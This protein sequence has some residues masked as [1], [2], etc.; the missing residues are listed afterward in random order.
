M[1]APRVAVLGGTFDPF[2]LGHLAVAVQARDVL[3]AET[4]WVIPA[5][6]PPLRGHVHA[7]FRDRLDICRAV[8][9]GMEK[10]EV[11]DVE[12]QRGGPS[13]TV[14]TMGELRAA[15]PD[16]ELWMVLGADAARSLPHWHR[17]E[18]ILAENHVCIVNRAGG[19]RM[20]WPEAR[21]LGLR[22]D[23]SRLVGIASPAISATLIR[24]RLAAGSPIDDLVGTAAAR[25]IAARRLYLDSPAGMP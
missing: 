25:L 14:D 10:I 24:E 12:L 18:D 8:V 3:I 2:H 23:R 15:H 4:A 22:P 21:G 5:A 16:H 11:L 13:Y 19:R 6:V 1:S 9:E 7:G 20:L 17:G